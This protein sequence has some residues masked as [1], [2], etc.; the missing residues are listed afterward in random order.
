MLAD[1]PSRICLTSDVWTA[2]TYEGYIC[3][4]AHFIDADWR[5]NSFVLSFIVPPPHTGIELANK[6][7]NL[8]NE[9][10][11]GKKIFSLTLDNA[12]NNDN[13]Q[14]TLRGLLRSDLLCGGEFFHI[15][16]CAHILNLIVREGMKVV[17]VTLSKVRQSVKYVKASESRT[18]LF[19]GCVKIVS[20]EMGVHLKLDVTTRWNSTYLMLESALK[21]RDAFHRLSLTDK[22]YIF[23]PSDEEWART[24]KMLN[25]LRPFYE[26][27][28][29]I[30][31][32][33][34]PTSNLYFV[35]VWKIECL[36]LSNM[37][38]EDTVKKE[39]V[40]EMKRKFDKYWNEYSVV[41][42]LGAVLDPRFKFQ[43]LEMCYN[44]V[45]PDSAFEKLN[46]VREKLNALFEQYSKNENV[47]SSS[48]TSHEHGRSSS[49][50]LLPSTL[51]TYDLTDVFKMFDS[52]VVNKAGKNQLEIYL[53]ESKLE[54]SQFQS[55]DVLNYWKDNKYR[56]PDLARMASDVLSIPIT[57]VASE[58]AFSIGARVL[59]KYR[60]CLLPKNVQALLCARNW[61]FGF[62]DIDEDEVETVEDPPS[63]I[64][65]NTGV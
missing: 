30:S 27:T 64:G 10:G 58:S 38:N 39:M 6:V 37:D 3:L 44:R 21:Y 42:A 51:D 26:I 19:E 41:L 49:S 56:F 18:I 7:L 55:L 16:C 17:N 1:A 20:L 31:G 62:P 4:T 48:S 33:S 36:L 15:R 34:Y 63:E 35:E 29:L 47:V 54:W 50:Q 13:M 60:S 5:L 46:H 61:F 2:C 23:L 11:I 52:Q 57:T 40:K 28:K 14:D 45:N 24:E 8:L 9:W 59:N 32:S 25:F 53:D 22:N 65:S 43:F 12:S